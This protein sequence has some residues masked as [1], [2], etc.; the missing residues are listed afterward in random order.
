LTLAYVGGIATVGGAI[1]AG[2]LTPSGV[3]A[4]VLGGTS[5]S[6]AY[7]QQLFTGVLLV[8]VAIKLPGGLAQGLGGL[9]KRVASLVRRPFDRPPP[10]VGPGLPIES[11]DIQ[12]A[13]VA[14]S[15]SGTGTTRL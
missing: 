6:A 12:S 1:I 14:D 4:Q 8:I 7:Y 15:I 9:P 10:S 2:L 11:L 13:P 5:G 3:V